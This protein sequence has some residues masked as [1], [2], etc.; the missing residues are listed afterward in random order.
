[1]AHHPFLIDLRTLPPE[2]KDLSGTE[3]A[4]FFGLEPGGEVVPQSPL[5]YELHVERDGKDLVVTGELEASFSLEC[6]RCLE[7]FDERVHLEHYQT[8]LE[9]DDDKPTMDLTEAVREDI[10][11]TLP[12]YPR[13]ENGNVNLRECPAQGRFQ[14]ESDDE[15]P[16][17]PEGQGRAVWGVLDDLQKNRQS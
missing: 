8:E 4:A 11:L 7:R 13:C 9:L 6:G 2:G 17:Q 16:V 12:S 3:T 14:S 1:M 5:R 15:T 10:L